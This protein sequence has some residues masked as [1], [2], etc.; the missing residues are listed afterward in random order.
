MEN[1]CVISI[2]G[3]ERINMTH[4]EDWRNIAFPYADWVFDIHNILNKLDII[5]YA[6]RH[7]NIIHIL[8]V[9]QELFDHIISHTYP[10][11]LGF[12]VHRTEKL[13]YRGFYTGEI[14]PVGVS[15]S[16]TTFCIKKPDNPNIDLR[17]PV[18]TLKR[19]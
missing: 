10:R 15:S 4:E 7:E 2:T 19:T 1:Q 3:K 5:H 14:E 13:Y 17:H 8:H 12:F 18:I 16:R 6:D 11:E 9:P